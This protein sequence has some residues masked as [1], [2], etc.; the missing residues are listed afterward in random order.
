MALPPPMGVDGGASLHGAALGAGGGT[1]RGGIH[2]DILQQLRFRATYDAAVEEGERMGNGFLTGARSDMAA[3]SEALTQF[4]CR[5]M[6]L[7]GDAQEVREFVDLALGLR[8]LASQI[9]PEGGMARGFG[10]SQVLL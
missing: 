6:S 7:A 10:A 5:L 3:Q 1:S 2:M 4:Y 8:S 9:S